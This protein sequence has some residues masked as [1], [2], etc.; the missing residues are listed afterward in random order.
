MCMFDDDVLASSDYIPEQTTHEN[1][2][3]QQASTDTS[4]VVVD[5]YLT[6]AFMTQP[7]TGYGNIHF[8]Q[9]NLHHSKT[10][11][12]IQTLDGYNDELD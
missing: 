10:A 4:G 12:A 5:D 1:I 2:L 8:L 3:L 7:S 9:L 6:T 11:S